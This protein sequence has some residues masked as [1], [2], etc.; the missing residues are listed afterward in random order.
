MNDLVAKVKKLIN[1]SPLTLDT[2]NLEGNHHYSSIHTAFDSHYNFYW[3]SSVLDGQD[4]INI[5]N[6]PCVTVYSETSKKGK[7]F[8]VYFLRKCT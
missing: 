7:G 6:N 2:V 8:G 3:R 5:R 1:T 4:S